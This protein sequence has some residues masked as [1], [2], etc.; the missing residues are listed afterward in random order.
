VSIPTQCANS[1][2]TVVFWLLY[3]GN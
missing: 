3:W 2:P 1:T